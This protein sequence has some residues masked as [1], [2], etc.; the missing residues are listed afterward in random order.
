MPGQL[1][2]L[3][4]AWDHLP[5]RLHDADESRHRALQ[6]AG[7]D[8]IDRKLD[9]HSI[10]FNG[11]STLYFGVHVPTSLAHTASRSRVGGVV[12][13]GREARTER[14]TGWS[15]EEELRRAPRPSSYYELL[16]AAGAERLMLSEEPSVE[17]L[18]MPLR[19]ASRAPS[20]SP[21]TRAGSA[22]TATSSW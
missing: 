17:A 18:A 1:D 19:A 15:W 2:P 21:T 16:R 6:A 5:A 7:T 12:V 11:D 9:A 20:S 8:A 3:P 13:A 10:S 4:T 22:A 14:G